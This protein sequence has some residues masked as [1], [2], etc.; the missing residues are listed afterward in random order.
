MSV[1]DI[2]QL[3]CKE[4]V[5]LVTDYQLGAMETAARVTFEQHLFGCT[6]CMTYLKQVERAVEL[7]GQLQQPQET[8]ASAPPEAPD[9]L[10]Q[11]LAALFRTR[12]PVK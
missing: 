11:K 9:Q 7:T 3:T 4:V 10:A 1:R 8:S 5:E 6:W 12:K 2:V